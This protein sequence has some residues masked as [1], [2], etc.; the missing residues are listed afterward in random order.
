MVCG[1]CGQSLYIRDTGVDLAGKPAKLAE[2]PSR[3][4]VGAQGHVR[5]QGFRV[6]GRVR[7]Q[8]EDGFWD[9]WFLQFDNQRIGWVEEDEGEFTLTFKSKLTS[10][11]PPFD[12]TCS[13]AGRTRS[14]RPHS[15]CSSSG[16]S[17]R[18]RSSTVTGAAIYS[19]TKSPT[20]ANR[21]NRHSQHPERPF[22][23]ARA[24]LVAGRTAWPNFS[25]T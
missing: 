21:Q 6:L 17:L 2:Y 3:L 20:N 10:P 5:G 13:P 1:Y 4:S 19:P 12:Q 9:E 8:Y 22:T 24:P 16:C 14:P 25:L 11:L 7:Y 18:E 23:L 15:M